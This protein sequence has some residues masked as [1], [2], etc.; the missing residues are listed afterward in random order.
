MSTAPATE[1]ARPAILNRPVPL[2]A[3]QEAE[4]RD[5]YHKTVRSYC[6][7]EIKGMSLLLLLY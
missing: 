3:K 7:D 2:S 4:V 1:A 6:A 5:L